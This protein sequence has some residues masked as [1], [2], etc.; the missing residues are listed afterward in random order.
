ME[1]RQNLVQKYYGEEGLAA[2]RNY[3]NQMAALKGDGGQ[4]P[5]PEP[6]DNYE[7]V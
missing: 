7:D 3:K 2:M 4:G 6:L 5:I 1:T